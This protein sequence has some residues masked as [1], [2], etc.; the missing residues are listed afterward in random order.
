MLGR[1]SL[2]DGRLAGLARV[3]QQIDDLLAQPDRLALFGAMFVAL[4]P[5]DAI[6]L[7]DFI[8]VAQ[9]GDASLGLG[10]VLHFLAFAGWPFALMALFSNRWSRQDAARIALIAYAVASTIWLHRYGLRPCLMA[11]SMLFMPL[12]VSAWIGHGLGTFAR[13]LRQPASAGSPSPRRP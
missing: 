8:E 11:L 12:I 3:L 5:I 4:T 2:D 6:Y 7:K 13:T 1:A 9:S 10:S